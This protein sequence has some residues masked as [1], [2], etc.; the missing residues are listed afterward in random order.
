MQ[1]TTQF[2]RV[3]NCCGLSNPPSRDA[4]NGSR[5]CLSREGDLFGGVEKSAE[6]Q[7]VRRH[8]RERILRAA[9]ELNYRAG[10]CTRNPGVKRTYT[11]GVVTRELGDF[12]GS[13]IISGV[14]RYL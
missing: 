2:S 11:I 3:N 6:P 4:A 9:R 8:T 10:F 13:S 14:E 1:R 7:S 5:A 12:Y